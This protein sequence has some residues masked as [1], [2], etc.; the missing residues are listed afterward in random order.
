MSRKDGPENRWITLLEKPAKVFLTNRLARGERSAFGRSALIN[1]TEK[2]F[3][4]DA[5]ERL[6]ELMN[7]QSSEGL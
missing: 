2:V 4:K 7:E 1:E 5:A 3:G 6:R